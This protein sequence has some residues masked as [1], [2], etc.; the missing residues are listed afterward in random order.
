MNHHLRFGPYR[1]YKELLDNCLTSGDL[2]PSRLGPTK[3]LRGVTY[4]F[5]PGDAVYRPGIS[6]PLMWCELL[7]LLGG[8]FDPDA[9]KRA[10]PRANHDFF[11]PQ[12]AYG[13]RLAAQ[14]PRVADLLAR[15]PDTRRA[16]LLLPEKNEGE[17]PCTVMIQFLVRGDRLETDVIMRSWDLWLGL[18]YDL[19]MFGGLARAMASYLNRESGPAR[20][21]ATSAHLY[22]KHWDINT[23][24]VG[25]LLG[26][27]SLRLPVKY[28]WTSLSFWNSLAALSVSELNGCPWKNAAPEMIER[29]YPMNPR[30]TDAAR[31]VD[32]ASNA[33]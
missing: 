29:L 6:E 19:I 10:A 28:P 23:E 12:M 2:V 5:Q 30:T 8:V 9:L 33:R 27:F 17:L 14:I 7:Q 1:N 20:V 22:Q 15:D 11:T 31:E 25:N 26:Y 24:N 13:P 4:A 16:V 3:E 18:P 32:H 21:H